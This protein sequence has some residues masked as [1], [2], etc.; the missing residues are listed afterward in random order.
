MTHFFVFNGDADGL[1]ALQQLRL[2]EAADGVLITGVKRDVAL[3]GRVEARPGDHCTVLDISLDV[4]RTP[5][6][7]LLEL[8]VKVR[9]FDH[10]FAGEVPAHE[11]FEAHLDPAPTVCTSILVDRMLSGQQ[12]AWAAVGAFGDSLDE[13]ANALASAAGFDAEARATLQK[14][15]TAINYNA[16]GET[17]EDLHLPPVELAR[18]LLNYPDPLEFAR[19]SS[20]YRRLAE[21][22]RDDLARAARLEPFQQAKGALQFLLP[23]EPWARRVSGTVANQ[24][25]KAN[26]ESAIALL[27]PKSDG[28]YLVSVRVPERSLLSAEGFCRRFPTGG[29]R[30]SAA[31]INHLAPADKARF[32]V[33][34]EREFQSK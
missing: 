28:G 30:R 15:G 20:S 32:C 2:A 12:R 22:Y 29:G 7:A 24:L 13:P 33:E 18:E 31:G 11:G 9:Y 26:P 5:L 4:N 23:G 19:S 3:L 16:Y 14:L 27:S 34:F 8:G 1:C 17:L 10:H 21:G 6:L 25:A